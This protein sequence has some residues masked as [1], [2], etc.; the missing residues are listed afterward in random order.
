MK[1]S[2]DSPLP[3]IGV[4]EAAQDAKQ[5]RLRQALAAI[6]EEHAR[7]DQSRFVRER[8]AKAVAC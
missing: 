3:D 4:Q 1:H 6:P 7:P 8:L 5:E 2:H